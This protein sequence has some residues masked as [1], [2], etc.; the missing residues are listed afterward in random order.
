M[1]S[2]VA[3]MEINLDQVLLKPIQK[4]VTFLNNM[5]TKIKVSQIKYSQMHLTM[6]MKKKLKNK[7]LIIQKIF[8]KISKLPL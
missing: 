5:M 8:I 7:K 3:F 2:T 1:G 6:K 4:K